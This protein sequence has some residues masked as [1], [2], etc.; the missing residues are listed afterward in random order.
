LRIVDL[1]HELSN[2]TFLVLDQLDFHSSNAENRLPVTH[3]E[4]PSYLI[5]DGKALNHFEPASFVRAAVY[6]TSLT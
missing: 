4:A 1:S 6:W 5:P 2:K 3:I